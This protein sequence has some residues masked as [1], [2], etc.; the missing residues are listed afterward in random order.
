MRWRLVVHTD[1]VDCSSDF[2]L[3]N[4]LFLNPFNPIFQN[5]KQH[6]S[7]FSFSLVPISFLFLFHIMYLDLIKSR[8]KAG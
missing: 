6:N 5:A 1:T 3:R 7:V 8:G 4:I 2:E